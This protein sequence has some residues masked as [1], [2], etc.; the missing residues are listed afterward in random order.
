MCVTHVVN[1]TLARKVVLAVAIDP[2]GGGAVTPE[3]SG[4]SNFG[5]DFCASPFWCATTF[6]I[7][8]IA[9]QCGADMEGL[10]NGEAIAT[11]RYKA[12]H[13]STKQVMR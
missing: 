5:M 10:T 6:S 7:A 2:V 1:G 13:T 8:S 3:Q 9:A 12:N 4:Q 11:P